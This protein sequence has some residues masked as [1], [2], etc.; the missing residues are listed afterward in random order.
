MYIEVAF[1]VVVAVFTMKTLKS[2][3]GVTILLIDCAVGYFVTFSM[4]SRWVTDARG[5]VL[6]NS[7]FRFDILFNLFKRGHIE[8]PIIL[9]EPCIHYNKTYMCIKQYNSAHDNKN[10]LN[11]SNSH[12]TT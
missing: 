4:V 11:K 6:Q 1:F 5:E 7:L 8:I 12:S 3:N 9:L 10:T 2:L